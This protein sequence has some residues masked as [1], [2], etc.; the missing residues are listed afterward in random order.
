M[1]MTDRFFQKEFVTET[2]EPYL[3]SLKIIDRMRDFYGV[4]EKRNEYKTDGPEQMS[5]VEFIV[6]KEI[7]DYTHI[8]MEFTL[9]GSANELNV[10]MMGE[11]VLIL[12]NYGFFSEAFSEFYMEKLYKDTKD[13]CE[14]T[15][16]EI[17]KR[18]ERV[19][20]AS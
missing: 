13:K 12:D 18:F 1:K 7:D 4:S 20:D 8:K 3:L 16:E 17:K 2:D 19:I 10:K 15:I 6:T 5:V 11:I 14:K 9:N